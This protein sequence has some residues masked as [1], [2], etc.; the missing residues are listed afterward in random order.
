MG[1]TA[2]CLG[3]SVGFDDGPLRALIFHHCRAAVAQ[4]QSKGLISP[5]PVVRVH[6]AA[7]VPQ[8]RPPRFSIDYPE[9][10]RV[11]KR[12]GSPPRQVRAGTTGLEQ[13]VLTRFRSLELDS[14]PILIAYSGGPDSL[15]LA[16]A[17]SRLRPWLDHELV[18]VHVDHGLRSSSVADAIAAVASA[19]KLDLRCEVVRLTAQ[20]L[21][22]HVGVGTEE[23]ARRERYLALAGTATR[24]GARLL[25]LAHHRD[26]QAETILLHLLRGSGVGGATGMA[27]I[28]ERL[29]PWWHQDTRPPANLRIWRPFLS[30]PR[31]ALMRYVQRL[32]LE[33]ILDESN[34]DPQ[35]RRNAIRLRAL[36]CLEAVSPGAAEALVRFGR[37]AADDDALLELLAEQRAA[38]CLVDDHVDTRALGRES[39]ALQR[40]LIRRW[41]SDRDASAQL[42]AER[43]EAVRRLALSGRGRSTVEIGGGKLVHRFGDRLSLVS[44]EMQ[45]VSGVPR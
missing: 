6:P 11:S 28:T 13:R 17:L 16:A 22:R 4:R 12:S 2:A 24:L 37:L 9:N 25:A 30:E 15:A 44:D 3:R 19:E 5:W 42:T 32:G 8:R 1:R 31:A 35:F 20:H 40:R 18:A 38:Q 29:V 14:G 34:A 23:A 45:P 26:D 43:V 36:P 39:V 10:D 27:E 21:D 7:P 33:P 41:L